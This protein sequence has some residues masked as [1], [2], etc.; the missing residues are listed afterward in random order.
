M[1]T[2]SEL[3]WIERNKL[4]VEGDKLRAEGY[5]LCAEG[6][7]LFIHAVI[8]EYGNVWVTWENGNCILSNGIK[9]LKEEV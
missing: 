3:A 6:D 1:K 5:K 8:K 9:F 4:R 7:L 2:Q